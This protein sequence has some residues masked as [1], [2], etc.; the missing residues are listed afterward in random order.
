MSKKFLFV[1]ASFLAPNC[2]L[3]ESNRLLR[4][5]I[6]QHL[7]TPIIRSQHIAAPRSGFIGKAGTS[8][9]IN[10]PSFNILRTASRIMNYILFLDRQLPNLHTVAVTRKFTLLFIYLDRSLTTSHILKLMPNIRYKV[11]RSISG[12]LTS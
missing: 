4:T 10:Q 2:R 12:S 5:S 11:A 8:G 1:G 9:A 7:G 3:T 6:D